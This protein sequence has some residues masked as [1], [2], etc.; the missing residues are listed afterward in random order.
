[1]LFTA[2]LGIHG[3]YVFI[4]L[5]FHR[6]RNT[7]ECQRWNNKKKRP[8]STKVNSWNLNDLYNGLQSTDPSG[9]H[10][11]GIIYCGAATDFCYITP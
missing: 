11:I 9:G 7:G 8:D 3:A 6:A 4:A 2:A 5:L 10:Q 1:M